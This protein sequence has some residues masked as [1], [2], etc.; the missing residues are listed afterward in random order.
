MWT[1]LCGDGVLMKW[2]MRC[3]FWQLSPRASAALSPGGPHVGEPK[4]Q[5]PNAVDSTKPSSSSAAQLL[6]NNHNNNIVFAAAVGSSSSRM[7][8]LP[9]PQSILGNSLQNQIFGSLA[10]LSGPEANS[11]SPQ[12]SST[13][14]NTQVSKHQFHFPAAASSNNNNNNNNNSNI[15][16]N[17]IDNVVHHHQASS[18]THLLGFGSSQEITAS[19]QQDRLYRDFNACETGWGGG[20][21]RAREP[22]FDDAYEEPSPESSGY[23]IEQ[24]GGQQQ[25]DMMVESRLNRDEEWEDGKTLHQMGMGSSRSFTKRAKTRYQQSSSPSSDEG[26]AAVT[27]RTSSSS[28]WNNNHNNYN[29]SRSNNNNN[30]SNMSV[31]HGGLILASQRVSD[32]AGG[33][34]QGDGGDHRYN[35]AHEEESVSMDLDDVQSAGGKPNSE[36]CNKSHQLLFLPARGGQ[37]IINPSSLLVR[38]STSSST[39]LEAPNNN[40]VQAAALSMVDDVVDHH[41]ETVTEFPT[42]LSS[43]NASGYH[44]HG[45]FGGSCLNDYFMLTSVHKANLLDLQIQENQR[46]M[47][48]QQQQQQ[49]RG[50][51]ILSSSCHEMYMTAHRERLTTDHSEKSLLSGLIPLGYLD[52]SSVQSALGHCSNL[53]LL[54]SGQEYFDGSELGDGHDLYREPQT[55]KEAYEKVRREQHDEFSE[56]RIFKRSSKGGPRRPNIIKGQWTQEEDRYFNVM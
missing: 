4:M 5:A 33:A 35:I 43:S 28:M 32:T 46:H 7:L 27:A 21:R 14:T 22:S 19:S 8:E 44:H 25:Q 30:N 13:T 55:A 52:E 9:A 51:G 6:N 2:V 37:E 18:Y 26:V 38:R 11:C 36:T 23:E 1:I 20:G 39:N 56:K 42:L 29:N 47:K 17:N 41:P 10:S 49:Q 12:M 3:G 54:S 16:I 53:T 34:G 31:S 45:G 40:M 24:S 15:N 48:Q 50:G